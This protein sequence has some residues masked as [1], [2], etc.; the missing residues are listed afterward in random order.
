MQQNYM[1]FIQKKVQFGFGADADIGIW[2]PDL[3][4]TAQSASFHD[5]AGY[6]PYEGRRI[7]GWPTTVVRRGEV[8]ISNGKLLATPGSGQFLRCASPELAQ[9]TGRLV[10]AV[11]PQ[12]NFGADLLDQY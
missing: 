3:E 7:T 9:P 11:N 8:V 10:D 12:K 2:A 6:C 4:V 1:A 5:N